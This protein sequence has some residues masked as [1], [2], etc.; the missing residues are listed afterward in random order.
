[1]SACEAWHGAAVQPE[2]AEKWRGRIGPSCARLRLSRPSPISCFQAC[3]IGCQVI[4][5]PADCDRWLDTTVTKQGELWPLFGP[6]A[7][8]AMEFLSGRHEG[9]HITNLD[10]QIQ[11]K[12]CLAVSEFCSIQRFSGKMHDTSKH[13]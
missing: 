10:E 7:A 11:A 8:E 1:V 13:T 4:R 6:Y 2:G 12:R 5:A 3:T 9:H